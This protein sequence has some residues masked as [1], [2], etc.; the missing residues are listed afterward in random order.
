MRERSR[1]GWAITIGATALLIAFLLG[2]RW[3][4]KSV[5]PLF[6]YGFVAG[7][8]FMALMFALCPPEAVI[9]RKRLDRLV[10]QRLAERSPQQS[11]LD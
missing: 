7:M 11:F 6:M 2:F 5:P 10:D 4:L 9:G 3:F 8:L 1:G